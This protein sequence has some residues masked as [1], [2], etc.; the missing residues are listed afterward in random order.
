MDLPLA[1][2]GSALN[3]QDL[4]EVPLMF[5]RIMIVILMREW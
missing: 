3:L 4:P 5:I 2:K 1:M